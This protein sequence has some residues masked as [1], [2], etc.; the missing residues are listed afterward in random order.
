MASQ[1]LARCIMVLGTTSG[2]GKSWLATALCRRYARQGLR[3]APFKAQNM[4]NNAR[5]VAGA[6]GGQG[7]IGSA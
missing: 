5:V 3:V 6:S 7:E 4:S 1:R 2:A